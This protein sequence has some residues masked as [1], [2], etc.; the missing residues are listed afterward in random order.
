[1][2]HK[3]DHCDRLGL[4][5]PEQARL[6]LSFPRDGCQRRWV[7][8]EGLEPRVGGHGLHL[9]QVRSSVYSLILW[10][11]LGWPCPSSA[12][13]TP[14]LPAPCTVAEQQ[15]LQCDL[16]TPITGNITGLYKTRERR[17]RNP[18]SPRSSSV[19]AETALLWPH[20]HR[21]PLL[22]KPRASAF[23]YS[24]QP[25]TRASDTPHTPL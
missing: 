5:P 11:V 19:A 10:E 24:K 1:V 18:G 12:L 23:S 4:W 16:L 8:W 13:I 21:A 14:P 6:S 17:W 25:Q 2:T 20:L 7:E 22:D 9:P 3:G 15:A